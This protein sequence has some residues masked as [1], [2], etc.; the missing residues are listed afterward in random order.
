MKS[1]INWDIYALGFL[2]A[3]KS[4]AKGFKVESNPYDKNTDE[5]AFKSWNR[6][7]NEGIEIN[8]EIINEHKE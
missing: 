8:D 6:G 2:A 1:E 4:I 3:K 5:V 7:W